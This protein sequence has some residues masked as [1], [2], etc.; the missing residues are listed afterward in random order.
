MG[1]SLKPLGYHVS[2][3][4]WLLKTFERRISNWTFRLLILGGRL[5]LVR[6]VLMGLAIYWLTLARI[7]KTILNFLR[8]TIFNFLWGN[9][10][11]KMRSHMVDWH[12]ISRPY[13]MGGWNILN[14]EWFSMALRLK[15]FWIVL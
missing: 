3:W 8:H 6:E 11:G 5:I 9:S 12:L 2:D 14:L 4:R 13:E 7:P 15:C 1:F 10:F